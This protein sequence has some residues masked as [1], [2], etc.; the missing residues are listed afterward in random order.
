[1]A[2]EAELQIIQP[3]GQPLFLLVSAAPL[4]TVEGTITNAVL[5]LHEITKLKA[6]DAFA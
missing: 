1:M 5:V 3:D 2:V 6:L 4:R